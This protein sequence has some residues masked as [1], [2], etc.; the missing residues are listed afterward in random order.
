MMET[1]QHYGTIYLFVG[2]IFL[3][4]SAVVAGYNGIDMN[5]KDFTDSVIWPVSIAVLIGTIVRVVIEIAK[6]KNTERKSK[7]TKKGK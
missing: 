5:K 2:A 3:L 6:I 4:I 1:L 7:P